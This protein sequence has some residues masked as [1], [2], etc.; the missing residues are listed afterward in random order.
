MSFSVIMSSVAGAV[1]KNSD[2]MQPMMAM[3]T[4]HMMAVARMFALH[5][6]CHAFGMNWM[7]MTASSS[8]MIEY[9]E[10]GFIQVVPVKTLPS[11]VM[12]HAHITAASTANTMMAMM[13]ADD[14]RNLYNAFIHEIFLFFVMVRM[15]EQLYAM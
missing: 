1:V 7:M 12:V 2:H 5:A 11:Y 14:D 8:P 10:I 4:M 15:I 6:K 3:T 9:I 13:H